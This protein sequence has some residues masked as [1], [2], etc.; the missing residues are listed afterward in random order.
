MSPCLHCGG[1]NRADASFCRSCGKPLAAPQAASLSLRGRALSGA[2]LFLS[3]F[4]LYTATHVASLYLDDSGETVTVGSVL[5]IGHPP[6]YPLQILLAHMASWLPLGGPAETINL[7]AALLASLCACAV[8]LLLLDLANGLSKTAALAVALAPAVLL[9]LGP[10]FWHNALVAKGSV[11][12]LNNLLSVL[13]LGLLA[14][15]QSLSPLRQRAFWL[16][17][18]LALSH[19]YMSQLPLLPAYAWLLWR[20]EGAQSLRKA[21][22][23]LPG[24][25]LYLYI[26]LRAAQHPDLNWG[27]VHSLREFF[28]FLFRIQYAYSELTRSLGTSLTEAWDSMVLLAREGAGLV[29]AAALAGL[30]IGRRERWVQALALGWL[31]TLASITFYLNLGEKTLFLLQAYLFPAYLCQT[32]LAGRFFLRWTASMGPGLRKVVLACAILLAGSLGAWEW[33]VLDLSSYYYALDSARGL[34]LALPRN[35]LLLCEGDVTVFPLWYLQRVLGE[36]RDVAVVGPAV[37]PMDWVRED[38]VHRWPDLHQ[39][40][41][42]TQQ[43]LG[44]DSA[45]VLTQAYLDMNPQRPAYSSYSPLDPRIQGWSL[46]SV[47]QAFQ[48]VKSA[49]PPPPDLAGARRRMQAIALRGFTHR[50]V[51]DQTLNLLI[52]DLAVRYNILG[53]GAQGAQ[54]GAQALELYQD[55]ARLDPER[56]DF[57]YNLGN[58]LYQMGR[59]EEAAEA[60]ERSSKADPSNVNCWYNRG[61]ILFELGRLPEA[62]TCFQKAHA[63]DPGR[64]DISQALQ[65]S[66]GA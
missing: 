53:A 39:P 62:H 21:W 66:A 59:K 41:V 46:Q 57:T 42:Q 38:L 65:Q 26:P 11:Y 56:G 48:C 55:A 45:P 1:E 4:A 8:F 12:H 14:A 27:D 61:V 49:V 33:P 15:P 13:L 9:C 40:L 36:R 34:L 52:G 32:L 16:I 50:P 20:A 29:L 58:L 28:F 35:A 23:A 30:W 31:A 44:V 43:R 17:L 5:G 19:H 2:F 37:L 54:D 24:L 51:D 25:C 10:V 6:G 64:A 60:F 47:G 63:L 7:L 3:A 18:G 22:L